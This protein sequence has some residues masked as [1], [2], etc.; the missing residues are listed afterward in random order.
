MKRWLIWVLVGLAFG[1]R[2]DAQRLVCG[3][4]AALARALTDPQARARQAAYEDDVYRATQVAKQKSSG[5]GPAMTLPVV[6][7]IIHT[8][9]PENLSDLEIQECLA[10][11]NAYF[12]AS[13]A[14]PNAA[15]AQTGIQFCLASRDDWGRPSTGIEHFFDPMYATCSTDAAFREMT[16][17][18][19]WP[20]LDVINIYVLKDMGGTIGMGLFPF[21]APGESVDG[22]YMV[23]DHCGRDSTRNTVLAHELGHYL[24]L[25]HTFQDGCKNH[26]CL[27]QGD[28]IC[29]TPPDA[30]DPVFEGCGTQINSC[31]TDADALNP[32]NPFAQDV[33]DQSH[34]FMDYIQTECMEL[35]TP[36]QCVRM[37]HSILSWRP[38]LLASQYCDGTRLAEAGIN[39]FFADD[40]FVCDAAHSFRVQV[41]NNSLHYLQDL[42]ISYGLDGGPLQT[43]HWQGGILP[44]GYK[45]INLPPL[46]DIPPG[47]HRLHV[48]LAYP[49]GLADPF[50]A[51]DTASR[52]FHRPGDARH[53]PYHANFEEGLEEGWSAFDNRFATWEAVETTGCDSTDSNGAMTLTPPY[54]GIVKRTWLVSGWVD[55]GDAELP[56]MTFDY[57]FRRKPGLQLP[58]TLRA[59]LLTDCDTFAV[60]ELYLKSQNQ[61]SGPFYYDSL[62]TWV[63]ERCE[64]W[65]TERVALPNWLGSRVMVAFSTD[66]PV[67]HNQRIYFD[68]IRISSPE[69]DAQALA[70]PTEAD[71]LLYPVPNDGRFTVAFPALE[72]RPVTMHIYN[73]LGQRVH[74]VAESTS[75]SHYSHDFDLR[76]LASG[77]YHL[78]LRVDGGDPIRKKFT[79]FFE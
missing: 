61:I 19:Y 42:D 76:G 60:E 8:N 48:Q 9:G 28:R 69:A 57:A 51:N 67:E 18:Y 74:R 70:G 24:G 52:I 31:A 22:I 36:G 62:H 25:F 35:F 17:L 38:G 11:V 20:T 4:D 78:E 3:T 45:W 44:T 77:V 14:G 27:M 50:P 46:A 68:N 21:L 13:F 53:L 12:N 10:D 73:S 43:F 72:V 47:K 40:F 56:Y 39:D 64:D 75:T 6:F 5:G 23:W 32:Q 1:G 65:R 26:D 41:V 30:G 29:D 63:P 66:I 49:N 15:S 58:N 37:R 16:R 34:N 59:Y 54:L 79:V 2:V 7:H 33:P 55:L 71:V